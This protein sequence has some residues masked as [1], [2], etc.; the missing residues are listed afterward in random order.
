M[1]NFALLSNGKV[2]HHHVAASIAELGNDALIYDVV[3]VTTV[4]PQPSVNWTLEDGVWFPPRTIN[5]EDLVV[6]SDVFA[7]PAAL[8]AAVAAAL[9]APDSDSSSEEKKTK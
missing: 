6:A 9:E 5:K 8:V 3:D 1:A 4:Y 2:V 7:D